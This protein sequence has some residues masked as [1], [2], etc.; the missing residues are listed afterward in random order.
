MKRL[1]SAAVLALCLLAAPEAWADKSSVENLLKQCKM[2]GT[3]EFYCLGVIR[4]VSYML[5]ANPDPNSPLKICT[6]DYISFNQIKQLFV[7]WA[8]NNPK[9]WQERAEVGIVMVLIKTYPC[10]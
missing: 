9:Q 6:P 1:L 8:S 2:G 7:N 3:N 4:G 10:N 5:F